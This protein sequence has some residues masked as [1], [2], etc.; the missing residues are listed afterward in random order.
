MVAILIVVEVLGT[1]SEDKSEN[2]AY[3]LKIVISQVLPH[4]EEAAV[5]GGW[6]FSSLLVTF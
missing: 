6:T 4:F 2:K 5:L 1:V 3:K